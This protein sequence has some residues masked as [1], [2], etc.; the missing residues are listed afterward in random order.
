MR[1]GEWF[2]DRAIRKVAR[3]GVPV[4]IGKLASSFAGLITLALLARQ[5]G[6]EPFG[7]IAVLRAVVLVVD[8]YANFNTWQAVIKYGSEAIAAHRPRDVDRIIKLATVIDL[9]T[10]VLAVIA[11]SGLALVIPAAF[12]WSAYEA[13]FV[14]LY[15]LT[16]VTRVSGTSDGI[17]RICDAYRLQAVATSVAALASTIAVAIAVMV[18]ASFGGCVVAL[19]AG[20]VIGNLIITIAGYWVAA[21]HGYGGWPRATLKGMR[22]AFPGIV[23]FLFATNAQLTVKK[24][25]GE[26]DTFVVGAMLGKVPSGLFRVV[27]QLGSIPGKIFMPFEQVLFTELARASAAGDYRGF[28][29]LLRRFSV[30]VGVGAL[31]AWAVAAIAA[32]PMIRMIAGDDFVSAAPAFRW[33]IFAVALIVANAPVQ[34]AMIALGRPGTLLMFDLASLVVLIA[35]TIVGA[36]QWGLE[37]VAIGVVAHRLVQMTWSTWLVGRVL[38]QRSAVRPVDAGDQGLGTPGRPSGE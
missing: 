12:D 26:L 10:G 27:K 32:E 6:P 8:Q 19:V 29:R 31:G 33:Y 38:R 3:Y 21:E 9:T 11:L 30:I 37:G 28:A 4:A 7:V 17:F 15:G 16:L 13:Q 25:S 24:T 2:R 1:F 23:H 22:Q 18:D 20:E 36:W 5:L 14:I 35:T 34:R